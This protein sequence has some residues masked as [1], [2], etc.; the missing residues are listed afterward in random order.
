MSDHLAQGDRFSAESSEEQEPPVHL[1]EGVRKRLKKRYR[2]E[3]R[4]KLFG[5]SAILSAVVFLIILLSTLLI[6]GLPA[7]TYNFVTLSLDLIPPA[8][9]PQEPEKSATREILQKGILAEFPFVTDR[10]EKRQVMGLLSSGASLLLRES[11]RRGEIAPGPQRLVVFPLSDEADLFFKGDVTSV[12]EIRPQGTAYVFENSGFLELVSDSEAFSAIKTERLSVL[13]E[14]KRRLE[15]SIAHHQNTYTQ[16]A[17]SLTRI[18]SKGEGGED[19]TKQIQGILQRQTILRNQIQKLTEECK[20]LEEALYQSRDSKRLLP[21]LPEMPSFL[22]K[23]GGGILRV[24]A[25]SLDRVQAEVLVPPAEVTRLQGKSEGTTQAEQEGVQ[26]GSWEIVRLSVPETLRKLTDREIAF[27]MSLSER[28]LIHRG[29]NKIF[30]EGGAS[31]EPEMAGIWGAVVGSFLTL[32]VTF[33]LSFPIGVAAALY[34]E[35]FAPKNRLTALLEVNINNLASV[36]SIIFGLLG[37]AVFLNGFGLPRSAPIVGGIVLALMTLPTIIIAA[38]AALKA[39][40][41]SIREAA[42]GIGASDIQI[43]FHH[44][45]PLALPGIL[46]GTIIG[47]AQALGET[48]PLLMIGMVAFI[49]DI[50]SGLFDPATVLPVQIFMWADFP[51]PAFQQKTSAA[52]L[53]LLFFLLLMNGVALLLRKKF[54]RRW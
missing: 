11:L 1:S 24:H 31:R 36:P 19:K 27:L 47:M 18:E 23:L 14:K 4:F 39:V 10:R 12:D 35:E 42:L 8:F 21:V 2:A 7:F 20:I 6:K 43:A 33:F 22:I 17:D 9:D 16:N 44:T 28:G 30:F 38:R 32:I 54:E 49:V 52:I 26:A 40:P 13:E 15:K 37:L 48:A 25:V 50:P 3:R 51:E 5:L 45:L 53:V 29:W 34:L 41:P 46:T